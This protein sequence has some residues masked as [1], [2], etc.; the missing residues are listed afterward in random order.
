M[1]Q[2]YVKATKEDAEVI[3]GRDKVEA[4]FSVGVLLCIDRKD[5]PGDSLRFW[6]ARCRQ[7]LY[8]IL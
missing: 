5:Y 6:T 3:K 4:H 8:F 2:D 1:R 7:N